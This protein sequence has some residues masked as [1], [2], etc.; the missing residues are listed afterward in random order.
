MDAAEF[1]GKPDKGRVGSSSGRTLCGKALEFHGE[2]PHAS[3]SKNWS[4]PSDPT[5]RGGS[6]PEAKRR[7]GGHAVNLEDQAEHQNWLTPHGMAGVDRTGKKGGPGGGEF[8]K[9]A[10]NWATPNEGDYKR[11]V[12]EKDGKRGIL[13][14]TLTRQCRS[15]PPVQTMTT[16]G[17]KSLPPARGLRRRLNPAFVE[18]LM[19]FPLLWTQPAPSGSELWETPSCP[20]APAGSAKESSNGK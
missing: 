13:L 16:H 10:N 14:P 15:L 17:G 8:A 2:G 6:Q 3:G 18:W 20:P 4:T 1:C 7:H 9:M 19:G 12:Q 11:G 5:K